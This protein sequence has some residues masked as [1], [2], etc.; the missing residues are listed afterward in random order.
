MSSNVGTEKSLSLSNHTHHTVI[1][2]RQIEMRLCNC[3]YTI[4]Y[5][6]T[7]QFSSNFDIDWFYVTERNVSLSFWPC[8]KTREKLLEYHLDQTRKYSTVPGV[9]FEGQW[10]MLAQLEDIRYKKQY[11]LKF[12]S[13]F[14]HWSWHNAGGF[15]SSSS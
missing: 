13:T 3:Y 7:F 12:S 2:M 14:L 9:W 1:L 6:H 15:D 5:D 10:W 8:D 4:I 11:I